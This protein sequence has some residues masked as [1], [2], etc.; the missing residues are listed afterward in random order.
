MKNVFTRFILRIDISKKIISEATEIHKSEN[1]DAKKKV[2]KEQ[3]LLNK[4]LT[5]NGGRLQTR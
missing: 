3:R 5:G 1:K 4:T 2:T